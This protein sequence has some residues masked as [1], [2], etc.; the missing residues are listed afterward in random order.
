MTRWFV[1][2]GV[3]LLMI[4]PFRVTLGASLWLA[5]TVKVLTGGLDQPSAV[6]LD[7]RG[8]AFVLDG[9]KGRVVVFDHRGR[10]DFQFGQSG[11]AEARLGLPMDLGID[12]ERLYIA[13]SGNGR[14][15]IFNLRGEFIDEIALAPPSGRTA[16]PEPSA[17]SLDDGVLSWSDRRYHRVCRHDLDSGKA[18]ACWGERG[19]GRA[20][21]QFPFQL[22]SDADGY[23]HV[24][25]VLNARV[26]V[27]DS[28]GR[29]FGQIGRFGL[30]DGELFRPN[31][32]AFDGAGQ[33]YV[34]DAY[35]GT[36]SVFRDGRFLQRLADER[37]EP[38]RFDTPVALTVA[39]GLLYVVEAGA[40]RVTALRVSQIETG[41]EAASESGSQGVALSRSHCI[42]CHLSWAADYPAG[43]GVEDGVQPVAS[44]R[45][46][47]SCHHGAVVDSRGA[48][49][50]GEQH[51]DIHHRRQKKEGAKKERRD[52]LPARFPRLASG[53]LTCG[54]CHTP[55]GDEIE[56][57]ETLY[58][59]HRNPWLRVGQHDGGL[60]RQ[61][62]DSKVDRVGDPDHPPSGMNHPIG[63]YLKKP[64]QGKAAG[65]ATEASLHKGLPKSLAERGAA[66]GSEGQMICQSCHRVHGA[67][68]EALTPLSFEDDQLCIAC[69][70]R[71]SAKDKKEARR[72][73][74]H[75]VGIKLEEPVKI[76]GRE[77]KQLT[78]LACHTVH[79]AR[80]ESAA[81]REE[82]RNGQLCR[83]CHEGYEAV[84]GS[85]HDLR[86]TAP[87]TEN[88][89]GQTPGQA[90]VCGACHT[91][92]RG[93]G[94]IPSL[95]AGEYRPYQGKEPALVRDRLCL[96]C[97]RKK[98]VAG[99]KVLDHFSHPQRDL[100]L[101]SDPKAMPLVDHHGEIK[102]FGAIAC[103]TCHDPHRW[104]PPKAGES[105]TPVDYKTAENREGTVLTSF[106]RHQGAKES[107][108]IDCHGLETRLKYKYFHDDVARGRGIDYLK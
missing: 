98:G 44:R 93:Q 76:A 11:R 4:S 25:D 27:F 63:I 37:G 2:G 90:G 94:D 68:T 73:G 84:V 9:V 67:L 51:P 65:Y 30:A 5:E 89:L 19:E 6:A 20:A 92:H 58:P 56:K 96:D 95:Y 28:A 61:C 52:K 86:V 26:Q 40:N 62:H 10:Q 70:R 79:G 104:Q 64:P 43:E 15:A 7:G 71:Q 82:A 22:A 72:K 66:L 3:V 60:C 57:R 59:Q 55:H 33:L 45:M 53:D 24:V 88:R 8:R 103:I 80:R 74:I 18:M 75:P 46:C 14:I 39:N 107:F 31:G 41:G 101:R 99:E 48:I 69:H 81:L 85:D 1:W 32:L 42:A 105:P 35:R 13:D 102:P 77:F 108:C 91:L 38:L 83:H 49:G 21:F 47:Y 97:H 100:I 34:S 29:R 12:G 16:L 106:L 36:I 54:S 23:I 87:E 17:L 50:Q 78:C